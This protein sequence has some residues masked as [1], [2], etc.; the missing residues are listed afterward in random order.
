MARGAFSTAEEKRSRETCGWMEHRKEKVSN[1]DDTINN[2]RSKEAARIAIQIR[3]PLCNNLILSSFILLFSSFVGFYHL[4]DGEQYIGGLVRGFKSGHGRHSFPDGEVYEGGWSFNL[5]SGLGCQTWDDGYEFEGEW[6]ADE[7]TGFGIEYTRA[8]KIS[9]CGRWLHSEMK[10][11]HAVPRAVLPRG[12]FL[13]EKA[14]QADLLYSDG[15]YYKGAVNEKSEAHGKGILY[16][17][18]HQIVQGGRF[19][20]G[21]LDGEGF[22]NHPDGQSSMSTLRTHA[23]ATRLT[24]L[25][26]RVSAATTFSRLNTP[27]L[28]DAA[29]PCACTQRGNDVRRI[30]HSCVCVCCVGVSLSGGRYAGEH[31]GGLRE[32]IGKLQ[33]ANGDRYSGN[34]HSNLQAGR[35]MYTWAKGDVYDGNWE[36]VRMHGVGKYSWPDGIVYIGEWVAGVQSGLGFKWSGLGTKAQFGRWLDNKFV[37]TLYV[38]PNIL[39]KMPS[40]SVEEFQHELDTR[41]ADYQRPTTVVT[42]AAT[43]TSAANGAAGTGGAGNKAAKKTT[44]GGA[45]S[46]GDSSSKG[47]NGSSSSSSSSPIAC[48]CTC[49]YKCQCKCACPCA[50]CSATAQADEWAPEVFELIKRM[51]AAHD[52]EPHL[53]LTSSSRIAA[54]NRADD[55][56]RS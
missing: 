34:F 5:K 14:K 54:N 1:N 2:T 21:K 18:T 6:R 23:M 42:T 28:D 31:K 12:K 44:N 13:S 11:W 32:G 45:H 38:A 43:N 36:A 8:G 53:M 40:W 51:R 24:A 39:A 25:L 3:T 15:G 50:S 10:E 41:W 47:S 49:A 37:Q 56:D 33:L 30:A 4:N 7:Q 22:T 29:H 17:A 48:I 16:T 26:L 52:I 46:H 19:Q 27:A 20:H 9:A 35:G 55:A